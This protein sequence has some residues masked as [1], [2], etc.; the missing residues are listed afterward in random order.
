M[1]RRA[2]AIGACL[3]LVALTAIGCSSTTQRV[4]S[5]E[6]GSSF[7][8]GSSGVV[9]GGDAGA[10]SGAGSTAGSRIGKGSAGAGGSAAGGSAGAGSGGAGPAGSR[11]AVAG[12]GPAVSDTTMRIGVRVLS[13][14]GTSAFANAVGVE[15]VAPGDTKPMAQ[16]MVDEL[17][18][19]GGIAGRKIEPY[20]VEYDTAKVLSRQAASEH[21]RHCEAFANDGKVFAALSPIP[22]SSP[23]PQ[24]LGA[25]GI[26]FVQDAV[27]WYFDDDLMAS[28]PD[29]YT[30]AEPNASRA[31]RGWVDGLARQKF[32]GAGT[33]LGLVR[34]GGEPWD[35][36]VHQDLAPALHAIGQRIVA[37]AVI[38]DPQQI[39]AGVL[40][41]R[42]RGVNRVLIMDDNGLL[43]IFW[44]NQS[45]SQDFRPRYGLNS[46]NAPASLERN[47]PKSQ[48]ERS[49]GVGW[50]PAYDVSGTGETGKPPE[51]DER[52]ASIMRKRGADIENRTAYSIAMYTCDVFLFFKT[53]VE[54]SAALSTTAL[55]ASVAAL[56]SS[57]VPTGSFA[58]AF[59]PRRTDGTSAVRPFAF[60][61]GCGCFRYSGAV[62]PI[63]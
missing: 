44:M 57:Y 36:V 47:V 51:R 34:L 46:I 50:F 52:C 43:S 4:A 42:A 38:S 6:G 19:A 20:Y 62:H 25:H 28:L 12:P 53:A 60:E 29:F 21:Q 45:E 58:S 31:A 3:S 23:L 14:E 18:A 9:D 49:L 10:D 56:G 59:A 11:P 37:E 55:R 17:N 48:L 54:R 41:F 63:S 30:P 16:A 32:F 7:G 22:S 13:S 2:G 27:G 8:G 33:K 5:G 15:G 40:Q 61:T 1:L 26:P 39:G 24:C 35:R